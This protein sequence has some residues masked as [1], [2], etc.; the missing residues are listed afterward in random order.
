MDLSIV[1]SLLAARQGATRDAMALSVVKQ[2][3]E[4]ELG[5]ANM[6]AEAVRSAPRPGQGT[7]VDKTA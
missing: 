2:Q 4:M 6:L 5:I 3:H 7:Q 1:T